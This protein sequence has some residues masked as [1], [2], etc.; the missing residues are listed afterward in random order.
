MPSLS[1]KSGPWRSLLLFLLLTGAASPLLAQPTPAP[2]PADR[3]RYRYWEANPDSL[4]RVLATQRADTARLRT[5]MH[6]DHIFDAYL[7]AADFKSKLAEKVT[8]T[9]RLRRP[10]AA[11][12]RLWQAG[13]L[14]GEA[15]PG[16]AP[17]LDSLRRGARQPA[18]RRSG[19]RPPGPGH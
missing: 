18:G 4:R 15:R 16:T 12:Y 10:E 7:S 1:V 19:V 2:S 14:L 3:A 13:W 17:G 5:L 6:L 11:A 9:Q 8:L